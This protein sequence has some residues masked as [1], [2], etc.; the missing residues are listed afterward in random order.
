MP[1]EHETITPVAIRLKKKYGQ[2]R[3]T[4]LMSAHDQPCSGPT[5]AHAI[6]IDPTLY[7][8]GSS[9]INQVYVNMQVYH[10]LV[11]LEKIHEH[12]EFCPGASLEAITKP[13]LSWH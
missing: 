13:P 12:P 5:S 6:M 11:V 4:N 1:G 2:V 9:I 3:G 8:P 7:L 10:E